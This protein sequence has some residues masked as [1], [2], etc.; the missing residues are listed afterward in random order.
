M[1]DSI[2]E[3]VTADLKQAQS[4]GKLRSE[5]IRNIVKEAVSQATEEL[6]EGS[7]E[8]RLL[9]KDAVLA[10]VEALKDKG[11]ALQE[12]VSASIE[13][14]IEGVTSKKRQI[15]ANTQT[16]VKQLQA[17]LEG[18]EEELEQQID[19]ALV[20]I[21][22]SGQQ[23]S[24]TVQQAIDSAVEKL[25]NSEEMA[26]MKKRYAQLKTQLAIVQ[27]NLASRHGESYGEIKDHLDDAKAWYERA[28]NEPEVFTDKVAQK[29]REFE[30]Q[31]SEAGTVVAKKERQVKQILQQLWQ[32][33]TEVFQNQDK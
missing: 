29:R 16:E 5:N 33:L 19:S 10:V 32:S 26:L 27:A 4:Q 17:Q 6:K 23:T 28:K 22:D 15:I 21:K 3:K 20:E 30:E 8:I 18:E 1:P 31:L 14:A 24:A 13:G 7:V 25:Q 2:K 12:E 11:G 9:V